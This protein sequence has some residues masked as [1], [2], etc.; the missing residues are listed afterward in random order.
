MTVAAT[1]HPA[2]IL[3]H[4]D[5]LVVDGLPI[6]RSQG[7]AFQRALESE[8]TRLFATRGVPASLTGGGMAA[9]I[10][11]GSFRPHSESSIATKA[12]QVAQAV[13]GGMN[14]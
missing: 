1:P 6:D 3:L 7:P 8:L 11:A 4:I 13:Y 5:H 10:D 2:D 9:R 14:P 12:A